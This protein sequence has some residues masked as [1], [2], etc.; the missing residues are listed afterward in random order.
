MG[1]CYPFLYLFNLSCYKR[2]IFWLN[3][4]ILKIDYLD[5]VENDLT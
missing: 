5:K 2:L 1:H 3:N 4:G